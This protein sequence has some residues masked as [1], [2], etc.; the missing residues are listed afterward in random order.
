MIAAN[1]DSSNWKPSAEHRPWKRGRTVKKTVRAKVE[2]A[3]AATLPTLSRRVAGEW[4]VEETYLRKRLGESARTTVTEMTA[5]RLWEALCRTRDPKTGVTVVSL[6]SVCSKERGWTTAN[7]RKRLG[8][9]VKAGLVS[10][11]GKPVREKDKHGHTR[12]VRERKVYGSQAVW[13]SPKFSPV[14]MCAIPEAT[15]MWL[16]KVPGRGETTGLTTGKGGAR[17]G[18]GRRKQLKEVTPRSVT[19]GFNTS[20]TGFGRW[21]PKTRESSDGT[22]SALNIKINSNMYLDMDCSPSENPRQASDAIKEITVRISSPTPCQPTTPS[23]PE[24]LTHDAPSVPSEA[25]VSHDP[26]KHDSVRVIDPKPPTASTEGLGFTMTKAITYHPIVTD[27]GVTSRRLGI[28]NPLNY[29]SVVNELDLYRPKAAKFSAADSSD[30]WCQLV[31]QWYEAAAKRRTGKAPWSIRSILKKE[32]VSFVW[33]SSLR[34]A[35]VEFAQKCIE[36]GVSPVSWIA[37]SMDSWKDF[38]EGDGALPKA[39]SSAKIKVPPLSWVISITRLVEREE[40]FWS[41]SHAYVG[42]SQIR[43][44]SA[45]AMREALDAY[46]VECLSLYADSTDADVLAVYNACFP[47]GFANAWDLLKKEAAEAKAALVAQV[48]A[49]QWIWDF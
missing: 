24:V 17:I 21:V 48:N 13:E 42:N 12:V 25:S 30:R 31:Q 5:W 1:T 16:T 22:E 19:P 14:P 23:D 11:A 28:P 47:G 27:R 32:R 15:A 34:S 8:L 35:I 37:W 49:G 44:D 38:G 41:E 20:H 40:W 3:H 18:A 43:L 33:E 45:R 26:V 10:R 46:R 6:D 39:K 36:L 7:A 9:L 2:K 4:S 29:R